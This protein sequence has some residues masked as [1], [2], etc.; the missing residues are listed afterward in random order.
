[1]GGHLAMDD[2]QP[3]VRQVLEDMNWEERLERARAQRE[4]V[5]REKAQD[6]P[7][8]S[9]PGDSQTSPA[10]VKPKSARKFAAPVNA[11]PAEE[12]EWEARLN[13][14]QAAREE[15]LRKKLAGDFDDK[16]A[17]HVAATG[18]LLDDFDA[19]ESADY[20]Y[21]APTQA[22]F[23]D[24]DEEQ[25][26]PLAGILDLPEP[27]DEG[28]D[29]A[30]AVVAPPPTKPR[31]R[32]L[33]IVACWFLAGFGTAYGMF[34]VSD[35]LNLTAGPE[36]RAIAVTVP[37]P[38]PNEPIAATVAPP[39]PTIPI[40][41][42][43][44]PPP[45]TIPIAVMDTLPAM[46]FLPP[47]QADPVRLA[48]GAT[49]GVAP[50]PE[51]ASLTLPAKDVA[52]DLT[53]LAGLP[54]PELL[55]SVL[56]MDLELVSYNP[57]PTAF[58]TRPDAPAKVEGAE[59]LAERLRSL[60]L[61]D[62]KK[63][64]N[65]LPEPAV[66]SALPTVPSDFAAIDTPVQVS[67]ETRTLPQVADLADQGTIRA[68]TGVAPFERL[69]PTDAALTLSSVPEGPAAVDPDS[70]V[71][72][73]LK[74]ANPNLAI[75]AAPGTAPDAVEA[76]TSSVGRLGFAGTEINRVTFSISKNQIRYY[77]PNTAEA[78]RVL[79][80]EVGATPRDFSRSGLRPPPGTIEIYL[81]GAGRA[82][83]KVSTPRMSAADRARQQLLSRLRGGPG[84]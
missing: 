53:G 62:P 65:S 40:A 75:F 21:E 64:S 44:A 45:P 27:D 6:T 63:V 14:A 18:A 72:V 47:A 80:L 3:E 33:A 58:E 8:N 16:D 25:A 39:P 68:P 84:G 24:F 9:K 76:A 54:R 46:R 11:G 38:P 78:A 12:T 50:L 15:L 77:S 2:V 22:D 66:Y 28:Q 73:L 69:I 4:K 59:S 74:L 60:A 48:A 56:P 79:A 71:P 83:R 5:L 23:D 42:T 13:E 29:K 10:A 67:F 70:Y 41:A 32:R 57:A 36:P 37:P 43:V 52:V 55:A 20:S 19:P 30:A 35:Q 7:D 82:A 31:A 34:A 49:T 51:I 1:L 81:A 26:T 61:V 17:A